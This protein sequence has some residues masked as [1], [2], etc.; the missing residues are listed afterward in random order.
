MRLFKL[1]INIDKAYTNSIKTPFAQC[2][3]TT[4]VGFESL[5][6]H[7]NPPEACLAPSQYALH[8]KFWSNVFN[9]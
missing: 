1:I 5:S 8:L 2:P 6:I 4:D 9:K 7:T 3:E